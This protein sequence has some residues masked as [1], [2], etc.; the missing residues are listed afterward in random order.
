MSSENFK[1]GDRVQLISD[2]HVPTKGLE[3]TIIG[4]H[5]FRYTIEFDVNFGGHS[6][7][8]FNGK[9]GHCWTVLSRSIK[10]LTVPDNPLSRAVYPDFKEAKNGKLYL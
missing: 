9:S 4:I 5:K 10:P 2:S 3:G 1:I 8:R 6:G 7:A